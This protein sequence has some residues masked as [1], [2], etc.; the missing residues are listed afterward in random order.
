MKKMT[1]VLTALVLALCVG[2]TFAAAEDDSVPPSTPEMKAYESTWVSEDGE[3]LVQISRQ[4]DGFQIEAV[5]KTGDDTFTS[6]GYLSNFDAETKSIRDAAG[7]RNECKVKD[8]KDEV[9]EGTSVDDI[10]ASFSIGEDGRLT[11]KDEQAGTETVLQKIGNFIGRYEYDRATIDFVWN[12]HE[13]HYNILVSW[14]ESAWQLWDYQLVGEYDPATET[15]KFQGLKQVLTY[16]D[17]GEIDTTADTEEAEL[18]GTFTFNENGGLVWQSSDG[19][20]DGIVFENAWL[21][22]WASELAV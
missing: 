5:K 10:K 20:G 16:K 3:T 17:D 9:I 11:W 22:L 6:W 13:N 8:G 14:S 1:A 18:E 12:V 21:P 15:V 2:C 19:S 7:I 4:D